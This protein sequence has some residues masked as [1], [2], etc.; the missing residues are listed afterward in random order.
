VLYNPIDTE[1][2][3]PS[4]GARASTRAR[5]D[6]ADSAL[7]VG[8]VGRMIED[9]GIFTLGDAADAF[10][11]ADGSAHMLWVGDGEDSA[12]LRER[13]ARS[14]HASRHRFL[15]WEADLAALYPALDLL[16]VPSIYPEPFG[17]VSVEAQ[18]AAVP[19]VCSSAGGLPETFVPGSTG[20]EVAPDDADGLA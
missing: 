1:R 8:Y 6:L 19:V 3:R 4:P 18:A 2:F 9:K 14:P 13:V 12:T 10:L 7:V 16:A 17:R 11:A 20:I 5:L 15:A